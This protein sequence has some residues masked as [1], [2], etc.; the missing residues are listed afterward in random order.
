MKK[1]FYMLP[2]QC[3]KTTMAIMEFLRSPETTLIITFNQGSAQDIRNKIKQTDPN[4]S[5]MA[6]DNVLP[7]TPNIILDR[8]IGRKLDKIIFDENMSFKDNVTIEMMVYLQPCLSQNSELIVYSSAN[9][10]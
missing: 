7:A 9:R 6:L 10:V 5:Q 4:I 1:T 2:R 3:G 8:C